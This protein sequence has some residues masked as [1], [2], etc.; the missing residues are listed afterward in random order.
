[1]TAVD[2]LTGDDEGTKAPDD[3]AFRMDRH[4][5]PSAMRETLEADVRAGLV[6]NPKTL[7][8]KWF[9]DARGSQLFA[10]ITELPEYYLT[11]RERELLQAHA[12]DIAERPAADTLVELG[13]GTSEKTRLLLSAMQAAGRLRRLCPRRRRSGAD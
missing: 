1:V 13:S 2:A 5:P 9:Y 8:P 6:A 11:A 3:T 7:P 4:L 10:A 12:P